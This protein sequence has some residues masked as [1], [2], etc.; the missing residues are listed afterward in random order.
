MVSLSLMYAYES[1]LPSIQP[2]IP[3]AMYGFTAFYSSLSYINF[4]RKIKSELSK[5]LVDELFKSNIKD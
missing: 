4:R 2:F 3:L 1:H 5:L